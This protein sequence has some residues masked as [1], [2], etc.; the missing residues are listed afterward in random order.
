MS[1]QPYRVVM[2]RRTE[3][4]ERTFTRRAS[5]LACGRNY[6]DLYPGDGAAE[7]TRGDEHIM[8]F[9]PVRRPKPPADHEAA[10]AAAGQ[11]PAELLPVD[12]SIESY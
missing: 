9:W 10:R 11:G 5:A 3:R 8:T 2:T 7:V 6:R 4:K 1:N 12:R